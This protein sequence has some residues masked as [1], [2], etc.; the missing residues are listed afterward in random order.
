MTL[1]LHV[2]S[3]VNMLGGVCAWV[4]LS[5]INVDEWIVSLYFGQRP[6]NDSGFKE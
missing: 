6:I 2:H 3:G 4:W 1:A 5:I